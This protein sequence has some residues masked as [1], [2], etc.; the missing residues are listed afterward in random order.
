MAVTDSMV[1]P[2][3]PV[4]LGRTSAAV[5][6]M[7]SGTGEMSEVD[8]GITGLVQPAKGSAG[9]K[10]A[11]LALAAALP[12]A[13]VGVLLLTGFFEQRPARVMPAVGT[14]V[15]DDDDEEPDRATR[16]KV[17]TKRQVVAEPKVV[18][19][20]AD[21]APAAR[22][23]ARARKPGQAAR[24][25]KARSPRPRFGKR[26]ARPR[27]RASPDAGPRKASVVKAPAPAPAVKR[28]KKP[29]KKPRPESI[30]EGTMPFW[31]GAKK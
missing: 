22:T 26:K 11:A 24:R 27:F 18:E 17:K 3:S 13:V 1:E 19:P 16:A 9:W 25:R 20:P 6:T 23:G 8:V 7:R 28:K 29:K 2:V 4:E 10:V 30:G 12:L 21:K 5:T 14:E 31:E 15:D